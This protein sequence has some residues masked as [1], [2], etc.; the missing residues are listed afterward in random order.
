MTTRNGSVDACPICGGPPADPCAIRTPDRQG[1]AP[2]SFCVAVCAECGAGWT[3]P[4]AAEEELAAYYPAEYQAYVLQQGLLGRVQRLGQRVVLDRAL[5]TTPL[6]VLRSVP[7]GTV[8][9]VGCGRGDVAHALGRNGWRPIGIDPSAAACAAAASRGVDAR[10]GTL[11]TVELEPE[12]VDAVVMTHALEH[13][14]DVPGDLTRIYQLLRP[15]GLLVV[16]VPNFGSWQR[17]RFGAS[18][19]P[20]ELPRHRTHFT[21]HSLEL[22]LRRAGFGATE[23]T[24]GS[25]NGFAVLASMQYAIGGRLFLHRP[26]WAWLG[27]AVWPINGVIDRFRGEGALLHAIARRPAADA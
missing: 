25:D 8:L 23:V 16:T 5:A 26:P 18:W 19:F 27:Y 21:R 12:S 7:P 11:A 15:G 1:V 13:V 9:D 17:A 20:L 22:A 6:R 10:V 14:P 24:P 3:L 4:R 2:G